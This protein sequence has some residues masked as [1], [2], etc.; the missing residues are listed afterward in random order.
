MGCAK[1]VR[2]NIAK[3]DPVAKAAGAGTPVRISKGG[4][5][6]RFLIYGAAFVAVSTLI[7]GSFI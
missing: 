1:I 2:Q 3:S 4:G 5:F 6:R 7:V